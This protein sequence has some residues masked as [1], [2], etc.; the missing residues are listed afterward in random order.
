MTPETQRHRRGYVARWT[1]LANDFR[2]RRTCV[3]PLCHMIGGGV[4]PGFSLG[5]IGPRA[6]ATSHEIGTK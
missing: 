3:F 2:L 6:P 1:L 5:L 4:F